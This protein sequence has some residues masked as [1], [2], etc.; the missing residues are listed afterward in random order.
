MGV[1]SV[2]TVGGS[3]LSDTSLDWREGVSASSGVL[4]DASLGSA[5][6][7]LESPNDSSSAL[8]DASLGCVEEVL[9]CAD[10]GL[11][12][13]EEEEVFA[14]PDDESSAL[15]PDASSSR[16]AISGSAL[17]L[18]D[19]ETGFPARSTKTFSGSFAGTAESWTFESLRGTAFISAGLPSRSMKTF[20]VSFAGT[21]ESWTFESLRGTVFDSAD[22]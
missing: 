7:V 14:S 4:A 3:F 10:S 20:S 18:F 9:C 16:N 8:A 17:P 19:L 5:E 2:G 22:G 15:L 12:A 1:S 21:A 11:G 6:E 13:S